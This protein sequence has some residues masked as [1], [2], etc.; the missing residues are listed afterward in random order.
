M[1]SLGTVL[2]H[3]PEEQLIAQ[4]YDQAVIMFESTTK[5]QDYARTA[6]QPP[7]S[8]FNPLRVPSIDEADD[9]EEGAVQTFS[10]KTPANHQQH[11]IT[12]T[13]SSMLRGGST[14]L[15]RRSF[16]SVDITPGKSVLDSALPLINSAKISQKG[17]D[18]T[19]SVSVTFRGDGIAT[20]NRSRSSSHD[21]SIAEQKTEEQ[22]PKGGRSSFS[23]RSMQVVDALLSKAESHTELSRRGFSDREHR[24]KKPQPSLRPSPRER[25]SVDLSLSETSSILGD[26]PPAQQSPETVS[27]RSS[28]VQTSF[29]TR[30]FVHKEGQNHDQSGE[31]PRHHAH[32]QLQHHSQQIETQTQPAPAVSPLAATAQMINN[33]FSSS[34]STVQHSP[35]PNLSGVTNKKGLD[36]NIL[37][38]YRDEMQEFFSHQDKTE[39]GVGQKMLGGMQTDTGV[40][41]RGAEDLQVEEF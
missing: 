23:K 5:Q 21:V 12:S 11:T 13:F 30:M 36:V 17:G 37:D 29:N 1:M 3:T 28:K 9:E 27:A 38:M 26:S 32:L 39:V 35:H 33:F 7:L 24:K 41:R 20:S 15:V 34:S 18:N 8:L 10:N 19:K 22:T 4:T 6:V 31:E 16:S 25:G 40:V 14:K 2:H